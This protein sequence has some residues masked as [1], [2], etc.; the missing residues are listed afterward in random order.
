MIVVKVLSKY[1]EDVQTKPKF[2]VVLVLIVVSLFFKTTGYILLGSN[3][4]V[5]TWEEKLQC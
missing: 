5:R 3:K 2:V 1:D 4:N